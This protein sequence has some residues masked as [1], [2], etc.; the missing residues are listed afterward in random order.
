MD[1]LLKLRKDAEKQIDPHDEEFD[2]LSKLDLQELVHDLR[3]HQIE[4]EMQNEEM[5]RVQEDL[6]KARNKY[7]ELYNSAPAG[8]FTIDKNGLILD[9]NVT[10]L[11]LLQ[12]ERTHILGR[13][14]SQFLI[15]EHVSLFHYH[16]KQILTGSTGKVFELEMVKQDDHHFYAQLHGIRVQEEG[17][18][19]RYR[20]IISNITEKREAQLMRERLNS[21]IES[22]TDFIG[23]ADKDGNFLYV[24]QA[25][26]N[27]ME[28]EDDVDVTQTQITDYHPEPVADYIL[29]QGIPKSIEHGVWQAETTIR[30][31]HGKEIP[32]SQVFICHKNSIGKIDL[33]STIIRDI[34]EQ[35]KLETQLRQA[36][37]MRAIGTMAGG[38]AHE[39]NNILAIM[40]GYAD[41]ILEENKEVDPTSLQQ[42]K[43]AGKR[44]KQLVRQILAFSRPDLLHTHR[45][46]VLLPP[47]IKEV[48]QMLRA[49]F[50]SS[51]Q[52]TRNLNNHC[53]P[54]LADA[55]Q[56]HQILVNLF[57]NA[58]QA[59][60]NDTGV[61]DV[62]LEERHLDATKIP[63]AKL[64]T[65][66][67]AVITVT[68]TGHG[69]NPEVMQRIFDPFF[70]TKEVGQ[71]TGL[72]L[73]VVH[74]IMENHQG[75]IMVE[76]EPGEGTT[77]SLFFPT[78]EETPAEQKTDN[79]PLQR[80]SE[81]ILVVDDEV[82]LTNFYA[83]MLKHHGYQVTV[84]NEGKGAL[85]I[86]QRNPE[87]FDIV[88]TD[89]TMPG[90]TGESLCKAL[91]QLRPDILI[92]LMTGYSDQISEKQALS[93]GIKQYMLK[94]IDFKLML[95][96]LRGLLDSR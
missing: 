82:V 35:K 63:N 6:I 38:I 95:Q 13:P 54:V 56:I 52:I 88:I 41:L 12:A 75:T 91:L 32:V 39:F 3:V 87:Q 74:G 72:G 34:S 57:N 10:G 51:I 18:K 49:T 84:C 30:T 23:M 53:R 43:K 22:T 48:L 26:K 96:T 67:Y 83:S 31:C 81:H 71:G 9:V 76:S 15:E 50:P 62:V 70:T 86:F 44:A 59:M 65:G 7:M 21:I 89:Q 14:L 92:I 46:S 94:P 37:K 55:T 78:V 20:L 29:N 42:I 80:G 69:M 2:N 58:R 61:L 25:G 77:F 73:S 47:L 19:P 68:D 90:L 33:F 36:Q 11:D 8:Y 85:E 79:M 66:N 60:K 4:L 17:K 64:K 1:T 28:F 27:M 24:N 40:L 16:H 45:V 93:I 5:R